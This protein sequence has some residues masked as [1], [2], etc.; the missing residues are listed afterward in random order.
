MKRFVSFAT[1]DNS[2][3]FYPINDIV[4]VKFYS[5]NEL[6]MELTTKSNCV[7]AFTFN[8]MK[9]YQYAVEVFNKL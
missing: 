9:D 5:Q 7:E 1:D 8:N 3:F 2:I 6:T 4:S